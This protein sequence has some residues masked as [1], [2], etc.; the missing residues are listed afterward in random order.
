MNQISKTAKA[1]ER[2]YSGDADRPTGSYLVTLLAYGASVGAIAAVTRLAGKRP[3]EGL[4]PWD[5]FLVSIS[6]HKLSR[7]IAKDPVTSPLRAPFTRFQGASGPAELHEEVRG[8]GPRHA[9]GEL[10]TCPFC[11]AQWVATA[12]V[13]GLVLNPRFTRLAAATMTAVGVADWLQLGYAWLQQRAQG[14]G[15]EE[16]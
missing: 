7:L 10:V 16:G 5:L 14:D 9:I 4:S 3:P 11:M 2:A 6:T 1:E 13:A 12:H 15:D 8:S